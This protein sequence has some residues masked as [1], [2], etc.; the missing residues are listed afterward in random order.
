MRKKKLAVILCLII[1]GIALW[2]VAVHWQ[3]RE[4]ELFIPNPDQYS[5][6]IVENL[7][8]TEYSYRAQVPDH[9]F[10]GLLNTCDATEGPPPEDPVPLF[11]FIW[12]DGCGY[13]PIG[14]SIRKGAKLCI[15]EFYEE[16]FQVQCEG[17][18]RF[19]LCDFD[20][21]SYC[22]SIY[23]GLSS[24]PRSGPIYLYDPDTGDISIW[25]RN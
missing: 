2:R 4:P 8:G 15:V 14:A 16:G 17:E 22:E 9:R 1:A 18:E 5:G 24:P 11:R 7:S 23:E 12:A 3:N 6:L 21:L 25:S 19:Y 13:G 20:T 10:S